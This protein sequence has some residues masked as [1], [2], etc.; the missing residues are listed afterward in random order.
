M[1]VI[2]AITLLTINQNIYY[3]N[4]IA[5]C[6]KQRPSA[7]INENYRVKMPIKSK[8]RLPT[9]TYCVTSH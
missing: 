5:Y 2:P 4:P 3:A 1:S 8:I 6:G 7:K 9:D